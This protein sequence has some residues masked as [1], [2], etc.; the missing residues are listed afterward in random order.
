MDQLEKFWESVKNEEAAFLATSAQDRV[1]MRTIGPVYY[2]DA[3]LMFT[4]PASEKY[5]QL[6]ENPNCCVAVGGGFMEARAEF[7]GHTMLDKN[8]PLRAAYEEKFNGAFDEGVEF[9]G[10]DAAF[11]VF[12]PV[13]VK[14]WSFENGV[15]TGPFEYEF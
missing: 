10:R 7:H 11:V 13:R 12:R 15:P 1:T 8:A 3:I 4:D 2:E 9:G 6:K 14:G 5:R